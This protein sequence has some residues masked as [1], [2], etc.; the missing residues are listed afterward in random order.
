[1]STLGSM[2]G[3]I[4]TGF[5]LIPSFPVRANLLGVGVALLVVGSV[6]LWLARRRAGALGGLA[7]AGGVALVLAGNEAVRETNVLRIEN[8]F[9]GELKVVDA[10]DRRI[11]L[12]NGA[13]NGQVD[14]DTKETRSPNV[15]DVIRLRHLN[16]GARRALVIG[17]GAGGLPSAF[18]RHGIVTD[19]VEIDPAIV[20]IARAYFGFTTQGTVAIEDGRTFVERTDQ[21][22]DFLFLDA[23][24]SEVQPFHLFTREFFAQVRAILNPGGVLAINTVAFPYGRGAI[25]WKS[26]LRTLH[27]A[28]PRVRVF[29]TE[30]MPDGPTDRYTNMVFAA[31][32]GALS[33]KGASPAARAELEP[34]LQRELVLS[35]AE[36]NEG[37]VL[38][39]DYTPIEALCRGLFVAWRKDLI[40]SAGEVLLFDGRS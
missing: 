5:Y 18:T 31:S 29:T 27:T 16:P 2:L 35:G 9:Y 21:H 38:T 25:A 37:I 4:G 6:G 10:E 14:R 28:F 30:K 26:I 36:L 34:L 1:M 15:Q 17:L 8:S 19:V 40:E 23:F 13:S 32:D 3:A 11:L 12:I 7:I 22:Y 20:E 39:D 33:E 24:V